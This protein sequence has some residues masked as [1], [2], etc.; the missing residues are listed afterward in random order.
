MRE[1]KG[2]WRG[3]GGAE[4]NAESIIPNYGVILIQVDKETKKVG[5]EMV[6]Q[7]EGGLV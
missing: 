7:K 4:R 2:S 6:K 1:K 5:K 3:S